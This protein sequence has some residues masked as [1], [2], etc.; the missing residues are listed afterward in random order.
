MVDTQADGLK[1]VLGKER[2][3]DRTPKEPRWRLP[4]DEN[5]KISGSNAFFDA[6]HV[7]PVARS[8]I[9]GRRLYVA[10]DSLKYGLWRPSQRD[11][12]NPKIVLHP[13]EEGE[14]AHVYGWQRATLTEPHL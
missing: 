9:W 13:T 4:I 10:S 8:V 5:C 1:V 3:L 7:N 6:C 11:V 12:Q 14:R 2:G